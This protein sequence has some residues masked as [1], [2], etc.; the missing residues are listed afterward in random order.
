MK[1]EEVLIHKKSL[2][3]QVYEV[4]KKWILDLK[5]SPGE[6]L[7]TQEIGRILNVSH[8]PVRDAMN[9]L[10][11]EGLIKVK[12]RVGY[13]VEELMIHD[14]EQLFGVRQLLESYALREKFSP[15]P[16]KELQE[17]KTILE[18]QEKLPG[19]ERS[20]EILEDVDIKLHRNLIIGRSE[21]HYIKEFYQSILNRLTISM[22]LGHRY[23][24]DVEEHTQLIDSWLDRK[25]EQTLEHLVYHLANVKDDLV[26]KLGKSEADQEIR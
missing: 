11:Q 14:V 15:V 22:H 26:L 25:Y 23:G 3:N 6:R 7:D 18:A 2:S 1:T 10:L 17:L 12:P 4:I 19:E 5:F 16:E 13:F 24:K 8:A 21:N 20:I 9:R